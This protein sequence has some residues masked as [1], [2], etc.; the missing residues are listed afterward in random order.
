MNIR[1]Q[2]HRA[3]AVN[4]MQSHVF[5]RKNWDVGSNILCYDEDLRNYVAARIVSVTADVLRI[6]MELGDA[7]FYRFINRFDYRVLPRPSD[8][9]TVLNNGWFRYHDQ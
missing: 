1:L 9:Y 2:R 4:T 7:T 8:V 6:E 3:A 5:I